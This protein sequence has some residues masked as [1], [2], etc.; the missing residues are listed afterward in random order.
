MSTVQGCSPSVHASE[1][2]RVCRDCHA[3]VS[4]GL[5]EGSTWLH[6]VPESEALCDGA[7]V[8]FDEHVAA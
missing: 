8:P 6:C 2:V 5:R 3:F 7:L 4:P 1:E